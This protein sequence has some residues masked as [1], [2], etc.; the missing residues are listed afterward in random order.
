M[1]F[2]IELFRKLVSPP[3]SPAP[4]VSPLTT[5]VST[6]P[7]SR[8]SPTSTALRT[9]RPVSSSSPARAVSSRS[10]TRLLRRSTPPRPP[11]PLRARPRAT[12]LTSALPSPSRTL[13]PRRPSPRSSVTACPRARKLLTG[14]CGTPVATPVNVVSGRSVRRTRLRRLLLPRNKLDFQA[15][16]IWSFFS[17]VGV[18]LNVLCVAWRGLYFF[19]TSVGNP[20]KCSE[21]FK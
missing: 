13:S 1:G 8:S 14:G 6:T 5:A 7:R 11:S 17:Q 21:P 12:P 20:K 18:Y 15:M 9:T 3:S 10:S 19:T 2:F 4:S 16:M